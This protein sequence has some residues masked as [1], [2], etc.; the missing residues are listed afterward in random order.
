MHR[1]RL[2]EMGPREAQAFIDSQLPNRRLNRGKALALAGAM[3]R[4][5]WLFNGDPIR[6]SDT[7]QGLDGQHRAAAILRTGMRFTFV[8]VW[9]IDPRAQITID[10][11]ARRSLADTLY[12]CDETS[13][14]LVAST[15]SMYYRILTN[16]MDRFSNGVRPTHQQLLA[17]LNAEPEIRSSVQTGRATNARLGVSAALVAAYRHVFSQVDARDSDRFFDRLISGTD[18]ASDNPISVLRRF[19]ELDRGRRPRAQRVVI[20]AVIVKAWN[21]HRA[22]EI[23][24]ATRFRSDEAFPEISGW[25]RPKAYAP[26]G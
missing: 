9:G 5:E 17:L 18:L 14:H 23:A 8:H 26:Y 24:H 20:A 25:V 10:V 4:G 12:A 19:L 22:G 11:G 3:E 15:L 21:Q 7:N 6:F 16:S 2:Q 13:A 1:V